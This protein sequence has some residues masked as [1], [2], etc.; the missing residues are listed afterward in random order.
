MVFV[1]LL[2]EKSEA[3]EEIKR[4]VTIKENQTEAKL[5]R[6]RSDNGSECLGKTLK[7]WVE[8]KGIVHELSSP[9]TSQCNGV[10][11]RCN[12]TIIET[13]RTMLADAR[14]DLRFWSEAVST[15]HI[16]ETE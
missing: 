3:V 16:H 1:R 6:I 2:N 13:V 9:M 4:L 15:V 10:A 11:E 8:K 12:R 5:K 7:N 14:L